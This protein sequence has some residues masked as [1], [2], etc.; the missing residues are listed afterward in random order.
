MAYS[1]HPSRAQR[2]PVTVT[3]GRLSTRLAV[4]QTAPLPAGRAFR[5]VGVAALEAGVETVLE[6]SDAGTEGFVI[7]D[8]LQLVPEPAADPRADGVASRR[9]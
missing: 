8:A 5:R 1:S 2:V 4:D 6:V 7:L 9:R 3:S